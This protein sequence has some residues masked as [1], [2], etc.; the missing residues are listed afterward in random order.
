M[1]AAQT[2]LDV[3]ANNLANIDT[4]GFK[5]D[6][7]TFAEACE[8]EMCADG[9]LG[10][11]LGTVG[12]GPKETSQFTDFTQGADKNTG[13][14]LDV[15]ISSAQG[16]FAVDVTQSDGTTQTYYTRSGSFSL[17]SSRQLVTKEGY[18]VLD[19]TERPIVVPQGTVSI[20]QDGT[21]SVADKAIAKIGVFSGE[22]VKA[23]R[24]LFTLAADTTGQ[25]GTP[26]AMTG[27]TLK[28]E[29]VEAS[30]VNPMQSMVELITLNRSYELAQKAIQQQDGST[31][32]LIQSLQS[33]S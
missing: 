25:P 2:R 6:G 16:A 32:Q 23:G 11:S 9:G 18:P 26:T 17:D 12:S 27:S 5:A 20:S 30:N 22:F 15:A 4:T 13:N 29:T 19:D 28:T 21:V 8:R 10:A 24:G 33:T 31:Q 1:I 3:I 7:V 14:P